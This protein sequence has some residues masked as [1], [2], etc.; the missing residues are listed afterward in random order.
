MPPQI[1]QGVLLQELQRCT[2]WWSERSGLGR[3]GGFRLT[4]QN[5][6]RLGQLKRLLRDL[7]N[8]PDTP[9]RQLGEK[10][11]NLLKSDEIIDKLNSVLACRDPT[12]RLQANPTEL[13]IGQ[14]LPLIFKGF[15]G[16]RPLSQRRSFARAVLHEIGFN[17]SNKSIDRAMRDGG[18]RRPGR[19]ANKKRQRER[20]VRAA[21]ASSAETAR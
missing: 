5:L 16:L 4:Q 2:T 13:L 7:R 1:D 9:W 19:N 11:S 20:A 8:D 15:F 14:D 21:R 17:Y 10:T 6:K 3:G 12:P 18:R